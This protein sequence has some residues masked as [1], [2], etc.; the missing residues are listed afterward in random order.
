MT[1]VT[2]RSLTEIKDLIEDLGFAISY[3]YD[4]LIFIDSNAFL[5][6]FDDSKKFSY[7]IHFNSE[8]KDG[9]KE[10]LK[11]QL[12][13]SKKAKNLKIEFKGSYTIKQSSEDE[14]IDIVFGN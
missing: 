13:E 7:F 1:N 5:V 4:D 10:N 14:Q 6:Q 9:A 3:P 11:Q 2:Y 12:L 8:L